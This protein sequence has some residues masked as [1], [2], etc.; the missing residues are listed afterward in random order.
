MAKIGLKD[1]RQALNDPR[2]RD[3][4]PL[5]LQDD[6]AQYLS[7]PGCRCN[8]QFYRKLL[9]EHKNVLR[10]YFPNKPEVEDIDK[11]IESLATN[12]WTVINCHISELQS[13]LK[14]LPPGRKQ[15]AVTRYEEEVT[16]I[17]NELD[18]IY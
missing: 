16:A 12:H 10:K 7:D 13:K 8:H 9:R 4:L 14:S 1:V 6:I 2:F 17:V 11:E 3:S 18:L 15:I 5:E